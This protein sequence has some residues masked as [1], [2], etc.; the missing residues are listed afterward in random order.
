MAIEGTEA[1]EAG[2][3]AN[4]TISKSDFIEFL[5]CPGCFHL[6]KTRPDAIE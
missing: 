6:R 3:P 4:A 5:S 2:E 1:A